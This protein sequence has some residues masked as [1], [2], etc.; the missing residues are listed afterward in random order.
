MEIP[1]G[2]ITKTVYTLSRAALSLLAHCYYYLQEFGEA[3][4]AYERLAKIYPEIPEYRLHLVQC[5][6]NATLY[7]QA[8]EACKFTG[9]CDYSSLEPELREQFTKL[10]AAVQYCCDEIADSKCLLEDCSKYDPDTTIN[11]GCIEYKEG[12]F[13]EALKH[14]ETAAKS[15]GFEPHLWYNR[16]VTYYRLLDIPN[17]AHYVGEIIQHGVVEYPQ[18]GVCT[19]SEGWDGIASV[20]NTRSLHDSALVEALNLKA[21]I[22]YD[23]GKFES[24]K[25][26][27]SDLPPRNQEELDAIT[28]HNQA[29]LNIKP[30]PVEALKKLRFLLDQDTFPSE[31]L[32]NLLI[33]YSRYEQYDLMADLMAVYVEYKEKY[34]SPFLQNFFEALIKRESSPD[35]SLKLYEKLCSQ[36]SDNLRKLVKQVED[37]KI[38][39]DEECAKKQ[40]SEYDE[41]INQCYL[42]VIMQMGKISWDREDWR[43]VE[44]ILRQGVEFCDDRDCWMLNAA[45]VIFMRGEDYAEAASFY[46]GVTRKYLDKILEVSAIVLANLC[47]SY[48]LIQNNDEAEML[49]SRIESQ[50]EEIIGKYPEIKLYHLCIVNMVIG[51]MYCVKKNYPFGISRIIKSLTDFS[52]RLGPDTWFYTKRCLLS[53]MEETVKHKLTID[54]SILKECMEFL[55]K[56]EQHG[57]SISSVVE[58]KNP[59]TEQNEALPTTYGTKTVAYE[60]RYLRWLLYKLIE[61]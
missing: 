54:Q 37:Y 40:C 42:P 47:C 48:I 59:L 4:N 60:A 12:N 39:G 10:K 56:C 9:N 50:E 15:C 38:S 28:L 55:M 16:A 19:A 14:Y 11:K 29:I 13:Q 31:T 17:A 21:A 3:A 24:A 25:K 51:T 41:M 53:L 5:L 58:E 32:Q 33:L 36:L 34:L 7:E 1:R 6:Y 45:H 44:K 43:G 22:E 57:T 30:N 52:I 18:L 46:E 27:L 23:L 2:E 35:E 8:L 20:G 26:T 49:I 61:T